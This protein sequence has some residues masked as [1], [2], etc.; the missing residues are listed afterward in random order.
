MDMKE[1]EARRLVVPSS[2]GYGDKGIGPIPGK[3]TLYFEM[4]L[5]KVEKMEELSDEA[6]KWLAEHPL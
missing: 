5:T 1:G 6:K 3:A 2:L 4:K